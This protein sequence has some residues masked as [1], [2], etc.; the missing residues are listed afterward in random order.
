LAG[1]DPDTGMPRRRVAHLSEIPAEARPLI[2]HL[3]DQRLLATDVNKETSEATIEPA[4]EALLRQWGLLEGWL[5][6]DAS[7]L[8]VLEGSSAP[9]AIGRRTIGG[10]LGSRTLQIA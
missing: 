3:V 1:I 7:L 2:Q 10:S 4:H 5:T 8:A 6:E 9:A